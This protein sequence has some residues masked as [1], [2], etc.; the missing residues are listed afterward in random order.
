MRRTFEIHFFGTK[1]GY[2]LVETRFRSTDGWEYRCVRGKTAGAYRGNGSFQWTSAVRAIAAL[3][4]RHAIYP[5]LPS[6][7]QYIS[8]GR[9]S[10]AASLDY[11]ITKVPL[12]IGEMFGALQ[13]GQIAA[14]RLFLITNPNQKR[15]GPV[16]ISINAAA[17]SASDIRVY[18]NGSE[19]SEATALV[20]IL[21]QIDIPPH[22]LGGARQAGWQERTARTSEEVLSP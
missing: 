9:A 22:E 15:P 4:L 20:S 18:L 6:V 12:W 21:N 16:T 3:S 2:E 5:T 14:R 7:P 10:L 13:N 1:T 17:L 8:G 19:I 11:A